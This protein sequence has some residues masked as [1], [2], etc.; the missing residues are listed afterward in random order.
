MLQMLE[1]LE[2]GH[3][4]VSDTGSSELKLLDDRSLSEKGSAKRIVRGKI[5]SSI[6]HHPR[7]KTIAPSIVEKMGV[8]RENQA[9]EQSRNRHSIL[10]S[11]GVADIGISNSRIV[12]FLEPVG[13]VCPGESTLLALGKSRPMPTQHKIL[14]NRLHRSGTDGAGSHSLDSKLS[15]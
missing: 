11:H 1:D 15:G 3:C 9:K 4:I 2:A 7:E 6:A 12:G 10:T 8:P 13:I 14:S 5:K